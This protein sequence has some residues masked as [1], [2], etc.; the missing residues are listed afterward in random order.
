MLGGGTDFSPPPFDRQTFRRRPF[1]RRTFRRQA[2]ILTLSSSV[3]VSLGSSGR[4]EKKYPPIRSPLNRNTNS[5]GGGGDSSTH[6]LAIP[7]APCFRF[8]CSAL[9]DGDQRFPAAAVIP[10][11]P[12]A[13]SVLQKKHIKTPILLN[14]TFTTAKRAIP[15]G[16][17]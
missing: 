6:G 12:A 4:L 5:T 9:I 2:W 13:P 1:R 14:S 7:V 16:Y 10:P 11:Q 15:L 8:G 17:H 3:T